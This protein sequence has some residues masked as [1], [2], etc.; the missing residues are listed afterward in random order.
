MNGF[1][2]AIAPRCLVFWDLRIALRCQRAS[3]ASGR[4]PRFLLA[5]A[6]HLALSVCRSND[7]R[8]TSLQACQGVGQPWPRV[9]RQRPRNRRP[10]QRGPAPEFRDVTILLAHRGVDSCARVLSPQQCWGT[11]G[12]SAGDVVQVGCMELLVL[13]SRC[14]MIRLTP[15]CVFAGQANG[16]AISRRVRLHCL[17]TAAVV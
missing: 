17:P 1:R 15:L 4:R 9:Y 2:W 14:R 7:A 13:V 10:R 11:L 12:D 5:A 3:E 16:Q 6:P 8:A